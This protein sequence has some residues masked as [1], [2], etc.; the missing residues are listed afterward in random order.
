M[1]RHPEADI[2]ESVFLALV[3]DSVPPYAEEEEIRSAAFSDTVDVK[4]D[5]QWFRVSSVPID[6]PISVEEHRAGT[7]RALQGEA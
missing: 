6:E 3:G 7:D 4:V 5:G 1:N 2:A